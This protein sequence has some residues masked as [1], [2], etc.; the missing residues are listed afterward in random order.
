MNTQKL[1]EELSPQDA[2]QEL[3]RLAEVLTQANAD[4]HQADAPKL[5]DAE[6]DTLKRR[7][8]AIEDRFPDLKRKDSPTDHVGAAPTEGFGKIPHAVR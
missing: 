1:V 4:Y 7:N 5:S 6:Y 8:A 3:A 2:A